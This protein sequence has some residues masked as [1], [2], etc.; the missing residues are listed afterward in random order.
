MDVQTGVVLDEGVAAPIEPDISTTEPVEPDAEPDTGEGNDAVAAQAAK[1]D[2]IMKAMLGERQ[3][4]QFAEHQLNSM[5]VEMRELKARMAEQ[6][7]ANHDP[8]EFLSRADWEKQT[9]KQ[10][11]LQGAGQNRAAFVAMSEITARQ[12]YPD[13]EEVLTEYLPEVLETPGVRSVI[14]NS[15]NPAITA[16]RLACSN[17][18]YLDKLKK[19]TAVS[20]TKKVAE[21]IAG[22]KQAPLSGTNTSGKV[23]KDVMTMTDA[24]FAKYK[25]QIK[26]EI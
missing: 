24:E 8:N 14:E 16:Y 7:K 6:E 21:K 15:P 10:T 2:G 17:E 4:R 19:E 1:D 23:D 5:M 20:A 26:G 22:Q 3:R 13:F 11:E 9:S 18:R 12:V 25:A